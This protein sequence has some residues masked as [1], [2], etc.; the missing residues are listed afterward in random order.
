MLKE[1]VTVVALN[2]VDLHSQFMYANAS[3]IYNDSTDNELTSWLN[4]AI[5]LATN[6]TDQNPLINQYVT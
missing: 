6:R 1:S 4:N 5:S 2:Y 3:A